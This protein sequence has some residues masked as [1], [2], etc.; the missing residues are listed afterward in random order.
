M[1]GRSWSI[2]ICAGERKGRCPDKA[3]ACEMRLWELVPLMG[4]KRAQGGAKLRHNAMILQGV[5][6]PGYPHRSAIV[7]CVKFS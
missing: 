6:L 4:T 1:P 7:F 5:R 3:T 2:R